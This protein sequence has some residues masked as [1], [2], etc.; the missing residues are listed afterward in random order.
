MNVNRSTERTVRTGIL[1]PG[2]P[3]DVDGVPVDHQ[4]THAADISMTEHSGPKDWRY[5]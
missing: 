1:L 5:G 3:R 4:V 2:V